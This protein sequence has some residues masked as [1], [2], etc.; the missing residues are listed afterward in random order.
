VRPVPPMLRRQCDRAL[1]AGEGCYTTALIKDGE[2]VWADRHARRLRRDAHALALGDVDARQVEV[3]LSDLGREAFGA[4]SGIVRVAAYPGSS[5]RLSLLAL[6]R[7]LSGDRDLWVAKV[8]P[9]RLD[10][11]RGRWTGAKGCH[12]TFYD[13]VRE[14]MTEAGCDEMLLC[15]RDGFVIEGCRSNLFMVD[16]GGTLVA[17]DLSRGAVAGLAQEFIHERLR[18][19]V[20]R[21]LRVDE[22]AGVGEII[23]VNAVRQAK[24]IVE[25]DGS[26]VGSGRPGKWFRRL[27][28]ILSV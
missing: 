16:A 2:P 5:G 9:L 17:P 22:L 21:D 26:P 8:S 27:S 11:D 14:S 6:A 13:R 4:G 18:D 24:P 10:S 3:A 20:V 7:D 28:A 25:L 1:R 23:A 15:D 19:V 12:F